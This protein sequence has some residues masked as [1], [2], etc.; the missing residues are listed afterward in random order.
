ARV[1]GS[2]GGATV[3][4]AQNATDVGYDPAVVGI[5]EGDRVELGYRR[6]DGG[7][8]V[9]GGTP[10]R[11][12]DQLV[13]GPHDE[14]VGRRCER[15]AVQVPHR[16]TRRRGGGVGDGQGRPGLT[17]VGGGIDET[18]VLDTDLGRI[19]DGEPG[20][21]VQEPH[22]VQVPGDGGGDGLPVGTAVG[23]SDHG[24]VFTYR[25]TLVRIQEED[26]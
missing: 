21:G 26:R 22:V 10:V 24:A 14:P 7:A 9:P 15:H 6:A 4:G 20:G 23:G 3:R 12:G 25:P 2:P 19:G 17:P 11:G 16:C 18:L 5:A 8:A 13:V 1:L